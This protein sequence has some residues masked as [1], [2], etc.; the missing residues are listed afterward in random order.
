MGAELPPTLIVLELRAYKNHYSVIRG[1]ILLKK[2]PRNRYFTRY[3]VLK[4]RCLLHY[5]LIFLYMFVDLASKF[6]IMIHTRKEP[7][8][9]LSIEPPSYRLASTPLD[10]GN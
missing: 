8:P 2:L 4:L 10:R 5:T 9:Y 6:L 3:R 1:Y 7:P